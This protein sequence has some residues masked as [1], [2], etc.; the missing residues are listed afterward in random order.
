[1]LPSPGPA[2]DAWGVVLLVVAASLPVLLATRA[3]LGLLREPDQPDGKPLYRALATPRFV[4]TCTVLAGGA[5]GLVAA[6]LPPQTWPLWWV[7]CAPVLVLVAVDAR[8]TWLPLGLTH[9]VWA[10]AVGAAA[11]VAFLGGVPLLV[12]STAGAV[13]AAL[14]YLVL[15]RL[16][17]G[18]LGFGDVRLAPVL[19]AASAAVGWSTLFTALVLGS[20]VGAVVGVVL[21]LRGRR[22]AFAYAPSMLAGA[23]LACGARAL[24][25]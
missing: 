8:T 14:L 3:V 25:G 11:L 7:L 21:A 23:F 15:W 12:R 17:R 1:V 20:L 24:S 16:S 9:L 5:A 4:V 22:G 19:G 6:T 13:G 10:G 18:G 2:P